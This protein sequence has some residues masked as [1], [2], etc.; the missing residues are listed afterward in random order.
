[1]YAFSIFGFELIT[2]RM[3]LRTNYLYILFILGVRKTYQ[4]LLFKNTGEFLKRGRRKYL[5]PDNIQHVP[6]F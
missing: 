1:M 2:L 5:S 3:Y 4:H 6:K